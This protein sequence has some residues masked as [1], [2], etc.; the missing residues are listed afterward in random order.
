MTKI[1]ARIDSSV[2]AQWIDPKTGELTG[3][4]PLKTIYTTKISKGTMIYEGPAG[5]QGGIYLGGMNQIFIPEP[6]KINGIKV[7]SSKPIR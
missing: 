6:W 5:Y 4:S 7:I 2:K 3:A 1:Q